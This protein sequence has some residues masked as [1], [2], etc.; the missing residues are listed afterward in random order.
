MTMLTI[1]KGTLNILIKGDWDKDALIEKLAVKHPDIFM[2]LMHD[3]D[4]VY[5]VQLAYYSDKDRP[6]KVSAIKTYRTLTGTSLKD[7]KE[8]VERMIENGDIS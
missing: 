8:A 6:N 3:D 7:A 4:L 1:S 2:S 5:Q